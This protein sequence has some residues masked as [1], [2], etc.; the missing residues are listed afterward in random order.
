MNSEKPTGNNT[1]MPSE[2]NPQKP[3]MIGDRYRLIRKIGSGG[4]GDV[5][6]AEHTILGKKVAIK[7]LYP[8]Q[9]RK[10]DV[11]ERF[12]RE[13][14]AASNIGQANIVDVTDFG[15]TAEGNAYFVM[16]YVEGS[17]LAALMTPKKPLDVGFILSVSAQIAQALSRAHQKGIIHRDLKPENILITESNGITPFVKV[18]DFGISKIYT[19]NA[20]NGPKKRTLTK[21][22]AIFG[23]PEYMSPEQAG[24]DQVVPASDVY[25]LGVI[26]YEMATGEL[27]FY[28]DN[29]MKLLHKH[30]YDFPALPS[31]KNDELSSVLDGIIMRCLE[32][33]V[34]NRYSSMQNVFDDLIAFNGTLST[35]SQINLAALYG[36]TAISP[37]QRKKKATADYSPSDVT[38]MLN[39]GGFDTIAEEETPAANTAKFVFTVLLLLSLMTAGAFGVFKYLQQSKPI[40]V[41]RKVVEKEVPPPIEKKVVKKKVR[42]KAKRRVPVM[43]KN[44]TIIL[45]VKSN[46]KGV[47]VFNKENGK[48]ICTTP[49]KTKLKKNDSAVL[50]LNFQKDDYTIKPMVIRLDRDMTV[51]IKLKQEGE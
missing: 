19:D 11:L 39:S 40:V 23:T 26:M 2:S 36:D 38:R 41:V 48:F 14:I 27:P 6:L 46:V 4:M 17:S 3:E 13:A 9:S 20:S 42:R 50:L 45:R 34:N 1:E 29:Y 44:N 37:S 33:S 10:K 51:H 21:N 35:Q 28:D 5:F 47:Q 22:G 12:T 43:K 49:C 31:S 24:G 18:V 25:A 15:F 32:K 16:E 8:D 30:Q 7:L